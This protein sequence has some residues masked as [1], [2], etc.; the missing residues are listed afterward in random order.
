MVELVATVGHAAGFKK[1]DELYAVEVP[2]ESGTEGRALRRCLLSSVSHCSDATIAFQ[3]TGGIVA[4]F[5]EF[6]R[7]L[8]TK[9]RIAHYQRRQAM[10]DRGVRDAREHV[11]RGEAGIKDPMPPNDPGA[12]GLGL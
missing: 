1:E 4:K 5:V 6:I 7:T 3:D 8:R 9:R 11:E 2:A 10:D 12:A